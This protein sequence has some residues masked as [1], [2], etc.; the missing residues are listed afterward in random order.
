ML[1]RLYCVNSKGC[2]KVKPSVSK[3]TFNFCQ[4]VFHVHT[5][6]FQ[7][8]Q[9]FSR[10]LLFMLSVIVLIWCGTCIIYHKMCIPI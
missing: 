7:F 4:S 10:K 3:R 2:I 6:I 9:F 8:E 5:A 1:D